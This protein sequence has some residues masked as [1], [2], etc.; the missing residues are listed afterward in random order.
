MGFFNKVGKFAGKVAGT[1]ALGLA[2]LMA[3]KMGK[4]SGPGVDVQPQFQQ[5][6]DSANKQSS[7]ATGLKNNVLNS[8]QNYKA[9]AMG[10]AD[11]SDATARA[12]SS[13]FLDDIGKSSDRLGENLSSALYRRTMQAQPA[14][15]DALREQLAATGGLNRGSAD[16]AFIKQ[17]ADTS[18]KLFEGNQD[19]VNNTLDAR[20]GATEKAY[21]YDQNLIQN[22]LGVDQDIL[23]KVYA[24]GDAALIRE[25]EQLLGVEETRKGDTLDAMGFKQS[26]DMAKA[27]ADANR[28]T[29]MLSSLL[30]VGGT[31]AGAAFGGPPGAAIGGSLGGAV[32]DAGGRGQVQPNVTSDGYQRN[33]RFNGQRY[34]TFGKR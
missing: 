28:K 19:I 27:N 16:S 18:S 1:G 31:V 6:N 13:Q 24:S 34:A 7:L 30:K 9:E 17:S 15:N 3:S 10:N 25:A 22:R 4:S 5:I 26:A 14:Q 21:D 33:N 2:P 32:G 29:E 20:I 8:G 12:S 23:A 11:R